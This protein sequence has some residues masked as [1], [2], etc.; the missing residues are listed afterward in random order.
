MKIAISGSS[1]QIGSALKE[2]FAKSGTEVL[3]IERSAEPRPVSGGVAWHTASGWID[4]E[5]LEGIDAIVHLAGENILGRWSGEKKRR[6][7][8]SRVNG[9]RTIAESV[10]RL[11]TPPKAVLCAS[12]INYYGDRDGEL[13]REGSAPGSGFLAEVCRQWEEASAPIKEAGVRLVNLRTAPV[14][15]S[16]GGMLAKMVPVFRFGAG[17]RAGTG[18]QFVSWITEDD[19]VRAVDFI[20]KT[21]AIS[22]PVNIATPGVVTNADFARTLGRVLNRPARVP[23]PARAVKLA[24]GEMA[25][26]MILISIRVFPEKLLEHGFTFEYA[27]L[28]PALRHL[29]KKDDG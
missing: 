12:G 4:E 8:E 7:L 25:D 3:P 5:K 1:G 2:Y 15:S 22:G 19:L 27:E 14:L 11:K 18:K 20:L 9:T 10:R 28:E 6:I 24:M 13:L 21:E 17:G 29:L 26:E 23:A 16:R